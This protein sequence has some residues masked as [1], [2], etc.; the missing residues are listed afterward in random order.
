MSLSKGQVWWQLPCKLLYILSIL[1]IL[2]HLPLSNN[3]PLCFSG[4]GTN[5][6]SFRPLLPNELRTQLPILSFLQQKFCSLPLWC[7][8]AASNAAIE[9]FGKNQAGTKQRVCFKW[10]CDTTHVSTH[11]GNFHQVAFF[12]LSNKPFGNMQH[13][14][15]EVTRLKG[16]K[17][18]LRYH[19]GRDHSHGGHHGAI[20]GKFCNFT[21]HGDMPKKYLVLLADRYISQPDNG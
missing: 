14:A 18:L 2:R 3:F 19:W 12:R 6:S 20:K 21:G 17:N 8:L 5:S 9:T 4:S 10:F 16:W 1:L 11:I 13:G 7:L 15:S